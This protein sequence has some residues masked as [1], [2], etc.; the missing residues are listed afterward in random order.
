MDR[1]TLKK[2]TETRTPKFGHYVG[3]FCT[4]GI[5]H[6]LASARCDFV[7]FD[8][9]HSGLSLETLKSAVRYFEAGGVAVIV[10]SPSKDYDMIARIADAGAEG[11]M[12]PMV[13]DGAEASMV[14]RHLKY[15]PVGKRGVALGIA[16]DDYYSG[17]LSVAERLQK[18]NDRTT[19][20][21]LIETREGAENADEIAATP[22]VDCLWV[23]H[24]DLSASLGIPGKF[25]HPDYVAAFGKI[26]AAAKKHNLSLGR[27]VS[28][29][30]EGIADVRRGFD[31]CCFATDTSL[32]QRALK[33]GIAELRSAFDGK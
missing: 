28:T 9:E 20:F 29:A 26:V 5:G 30:A 13:K 23:G 22:G 18:S 6:I 14:V 8:M 12:A 10:R 33:A 3:E 11:I 2:M 4:P 21:A 31:F 19:F 16:H 17:D 7:F 15:P 27:L 32:Y 24:F 1:F 25:D